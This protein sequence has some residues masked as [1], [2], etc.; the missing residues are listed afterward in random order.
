M[1][2]R[3][4]S[5]K[6]LE[7]NAWQATAEILELAAENFHGVMASQA[8]ED[9]FNFM[10]NSKLVK[11]KR[12]FRRPEKCF[13]VA[14]AKGVADK[15]HRYKP[16]NCD[17]PV[18]GRS[19]KLK[20]SI[21]V[22]EVREASMQFNKICSTGATPA[23]YS[24]SAENWTARDADLALLR[25]C[26]DKGSFLD[27]STAWLGELCRGQHQLLIRQQGGA[28]LFPLHFWSGSC[29]LALRA[30]CGSLPGTTLQFWEP[31]SGEDAFTLVVVANLEGQFGQR[32]L[33]GVAALWGFRLGVVFLDSPPHGAHL[34]SVRFISHLSLAGGRPRSVECAPSALLTEGMVRRFSQGRP[35]VPSDLRLLIPRASPLLCLASLVD[36][37]VCASELVAISWLSSVMPPTPDY[38]YMTFP[39][40]NG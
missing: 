23:W 25:H 2:G 14:V 24:P 31:E 26:H 29:V 1:K 8:C 4:P 40:G 13:G 7:D 30:K 9:S 27:A 12:R 35:H 32:H 11:A 37:D 33:L 18:Q 16:V 34:V 17:V 38:S 3:P 6:A 15:V 20:R 28:W 5:P 21:F 22:P 36:Q 10:K 39:L 19:I